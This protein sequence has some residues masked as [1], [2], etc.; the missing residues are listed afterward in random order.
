MTILLRSCLVL[1]FA[2]ACPLVQAC[3][4]PAPVP[5]PDGA[6][7]N[8][9]D[10]VT[11]DLAIKRYFAAMQVYVDCVEAETQNL[12]SRSARPDKAGAKLREERAI[13]RLNEAAAAMERTAELF[14]EA[15][16]AYKGR[17]R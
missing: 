1:F 7:A 13:R 17:R 11:A 16:A 15:V 9:R 3:D 6:S 5:I 4:L 2:V 12:R 14:N 10:L 8:E